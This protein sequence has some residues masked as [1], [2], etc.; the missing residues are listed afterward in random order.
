MTREEKIEQLI[1][2]E[3]EDFQNVQ[4]EGGRAACQDDP[5]TFFIMRRSQ[6]LPWTEEVIDSYIADLQAAREEGRNLLAEK[7][8]WM[9]EHTAP[10]QFRAIRH[11]LKGPSLGGEQLIDEI[12][13]IQLTWM[14]EYRN[15]Y[16]ALASGN[17]ALYAEEDTPYDTS[18]ETYLRGELH[19]YSDLTLRRYLNFLKDLKKAGKNLTLMIMEE[20]VKAYGYRDLDDAEKRMTKGV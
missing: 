19:T 15:A 18:F 2:M 5:K 6:F 3:W 17:R 10:E 8:G 14:R 9:M 7:Y 12:A 13:D 20:E 1:K 4:N 11:L 16:P